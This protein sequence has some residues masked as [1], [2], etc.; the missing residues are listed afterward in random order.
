MT[1][2]RPAL[3]GYRLLAP[4][5]PGF[6]GSQPPAK[7]WDVTDYANFLDDFL[8]KLRIT[9]VSLLIG[10]S[11]GG[12]I[13][14]DAIG[15]GLISPKKLVLLAS[16]GLLE[17]KTVKGSAVSAMSKVGKFMPKS[18]RSSIG[19]KFASP[20]FLE[21][22]GVMKDVF[23][24]VIRQDAT[25]QAEAISCATLLI[26]GKQDNITPPEMGQRLHELIKGSKFEL[27]DG[28]DH[29]LIQNKSENV[30][31]LIVDFIK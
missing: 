6:G 15:R 10:H 21:A 17:P 3:K 16:H 13:A 8:K 1:S 5:L 2:L 4:D 22:Q 27:I 11:F 23:K 14:L 25:L 28:A 26:Y 20:D 19:K 7:A 9:D 12:R 29:Y 24:K 31:K 18:V 30:V